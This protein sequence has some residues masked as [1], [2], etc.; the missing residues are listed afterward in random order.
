MPQSRLEGPYSP[1]LA[2]WIVRPRSAGVFVLAN[3]AGEVL[4]V[5]ASG[6]DLGNRIEQMGAPARYA[7]FYFEYA[8]SRDEVYRQECNYYHRFNPPDNRSHPAVPAGSR[9]V[10]PVEGCPSSLSWLSGN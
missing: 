3:A 7:R 5:G 8:G 4:Y 1:F 6:Y 9:G 10:C 2:K